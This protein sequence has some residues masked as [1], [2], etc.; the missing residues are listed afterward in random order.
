MDFWQYI[1]ESG[2]IVKD[3][4]LYSSNVVAS[5][6]SVGIVVITLLLAFL[7]LALR[8]IQQNGQKKR[9][10]N[11][12]SNEVEKLKDQREFAK[13]SMIW[14]RPLLPAA[15]MTLTGGCVAPGRSLPKHW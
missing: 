3:F 11:R 7:Y 12:V 1:L 4:I 15:L 10:I 9:A 6:E 8:Y 14:T 13:I 5:E 2:K